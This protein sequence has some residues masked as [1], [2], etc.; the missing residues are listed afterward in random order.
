M[1]NPSPLVPQGSL[2]E[3]QTKSRSRVKLA[4]F[5]V[6][7][8]HVVGLMVLLMQGCKR[9]PQPA[10]ETEPAPMTDTNLPVFE[11][12]SAPVAVETNLPAPPVA[13]TVPAPPPA[14]QEYVVQ[15]GDTFYTIGQ[16]LHVPW[17]AIQ[18]ANPNVNPSKL[19]PGQKIVIPSATTAPPAGAAVPGATIPSATGNGTQT[20]VVKSGDNLTKIA[21]KFG[22]TV[23]A[24][25]SANH[26]TTDRIKVGDKLIVPVKAPA[27]AEPAPVPPPPVSPAPAIPPGGQ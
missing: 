19:Q 14:V 6:V 22:T 12:T 16:K 20:Y 3:Q 25:R 13:E 18:D 15:R 26:L 5:C 1:N 2:L 17:K 4:F 7:G 11:P 21:A 10:P 8:V 27:P 9:E 24:L 23:K